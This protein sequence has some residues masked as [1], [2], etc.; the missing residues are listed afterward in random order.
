MKV[1]HLFPSHT[2]CRSRAVLEEAALGDESGTDSDLEDSEDERASMRAM[3]KSMAKSMMQDK[4]H[5]NKRGQERP[6]FMGDD[7]DESGDDSEEEG[8][9]LTAGI[10]GMGR[11]RSSMGGRGGES[12]SRSSSRCSSSTSSSVRQTGMDLPFDLDEGLAAID[13]WNA[14]VD[15]ASGFHSVSVLHGQ[16]IMDLHAAREKG[17]ITVTTDSNPKN[18]TMRTHGKYKEGSAE[19]LPSGAGAGGRSSGNG[20]P[21]SRGGGRPSNRASPVP[22]TSPTPG[23]DQYTNT[24]SKPAVE[25]SSSDESET[26]SPQKQQQQR[27]RQ[28]TSTSTTERSQ[29]SRHS[30]SQHK[31]SQA[32]SQSAERGAADAQ[33]RHSSQQQQNEREYDPTSKQPQLMEQF[34]QLRPDSA[35]NQRRLASGRSEAELGLLQN[36]W[37]PELPSDYKP[38]VTPDVHDMLAAGTTAA[39]LSARGPKPSR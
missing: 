10:M 22:Q 33:L 2:C 15:A 6:G 8:P 30:N 29:N 1:A 36:G 12:S 34:D 21:S 35:Y 13:K 18:K 9:M 3:A 39:P 28:R 11:R 27:S 26:D 25:E 38:I 16:S 17:S 5:K 32:Q 14:E 19:R 7:S 24:R 31:D 37:K 4:V 23:G 20:R